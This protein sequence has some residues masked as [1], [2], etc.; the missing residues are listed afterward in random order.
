MRGINLRI[1]DQSGFYEVVAAINFTLL[2]L[3]W[4]AV[5]D[6]VQLVGDRV[7]GRGAL[8][9]GASQ[10][11]AYLVALQF[12]IPGSISLL[13]LV[14]PD[15][16]LVWRTSFGI[17]GIIGA[18]GVALLARD[19]RRTTDAKVAPALFILLGVPLYLL[20]TVVAAFPQAFAGENFRPIQAEATLVSL[21]VFLGVQE[22][23][24]VSMTPLREEF[25]E[26][27]DDLT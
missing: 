17:A 2:G 19:L 4:V 1:V 21:I 14:A 3:W 20:V 10:A 25:Q 5:K 13:A 9:S 22:A 7:R 12:M 6:R 16:A 27:S 15:I 23:W 8:D 24:V 26:P 11:V 18:I